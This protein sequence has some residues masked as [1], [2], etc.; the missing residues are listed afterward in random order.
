MKTYAAQQ[1]IS[2]A[3]GWRQDFGSQR[4]VLGLFSDLNAMRNELPTADAEPNGLKV[5]TVTQKWCADENR[6]ER[7]TPSKAYSKS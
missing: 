4:R 2:R 6:R 5:L 7:G 1:Q 3:E